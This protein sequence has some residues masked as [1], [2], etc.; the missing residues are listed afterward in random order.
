MLERRDLDDLRASHEAPCVSVLVPARRDPGDGRATVTAIKNLLR[1]AETKLARRAPRRVTKPIVDK[2]RELALDIDTHATGASIA[3]FASP[4]FARRVDLPFVVDELCVVGDAFVTR[5]LARAL[6]ESERYRVLVLGDRP[7]RLFEARRDALVE[8]RNDDFPMRYEGVGGSAPVPGKRPPV[9]RA[10][11][12][13]RPRGPLGTPNMG[14][15]FSK[16]LEEYHRQF[17]RAVAASLERLERRDPLPLVVVGDTKRLA[18][19]LALPRRSAP[20]LEL[21]GARENEPV[22]RLEQLVWSRVET[23]LRAANVERARVVL[24]RA[25]ESRRLASGLEASRAAARDGRGA[26][27]MIEQGFP[28]P[29]RADDVV[30]AVLA[31]GGQVLFVPDGTLT[32]HDG[33]A[34]TLRYA[35]RRA[36]AA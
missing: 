6:D 36:R 20:I 22:S 11:Q 18:T 23:I 3:L 13:P 2:L 10:R 21:R 16:N 14:T 19:F 1:D 12:R 26:V 24:D 8:V 15:E 4:D 34:L 35:R 27:L 30:Q 7:T 32:D 33:V 31:R 9:A 5:A 29:A 25:V 17:Y 28:R